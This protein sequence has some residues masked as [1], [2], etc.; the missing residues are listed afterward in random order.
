M[1]TRLRAL[2]PATV[3]ALF[4]ALALAS[5]VAAG[6]YE[7]FDTKVGIN[8]KYPAFSGKLNSGSAFCKAHRP[9]KL[10]RLKTGADKPLGSTTSDASG[11]W[12][13][14]VS[15]TLGSGAYYAGVTSKKSAEVAIACR[16]GKSKVI[17]ID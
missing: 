5:P 17:V 14:D 11:R 10:W 7:N 16:G 6:P 12:A 8:G 9:V 15:A 13:I 2:V 4:A 3:V 1:S